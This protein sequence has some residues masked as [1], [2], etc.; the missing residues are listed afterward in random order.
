MYRIVDYAYNDVLVNTGR[1]GVTKVVIAVTDHDTA[2]T[3]AL[4]TTVTAAQSA[5]DI[6]ITVGDDS[7]LPEAATDA[8]YFWRVGSM[9]DLAI[10]IPYIVNVVCPCAS[11]IFF[12]L[13]MPDTVN[14]VK[15]AFV[16]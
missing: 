5:G 1:S 6:I 4:T 12:T 7:W 11:K 3:S 15:F 14:D 13:L 2:D 10:L 8:A 16:L 9:S